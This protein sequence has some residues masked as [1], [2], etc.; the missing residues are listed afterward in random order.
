MGKRL[1]PRIIRKS[2]ELIWW[3]Q[4][5]NNSLYREPNEVGG[6]RWWSD[7]VGG[8]VVVWDTS[9]VD[10]QTLRDALEAEGVAQ[11]AAV[12]RGLRGE[13]NEMSSLQADVYGID[14]GGTEEELDDGDR[15]PRTYQGGLRTPKELDLEIENKELRHANRG[16][17]ERLLTGTI[18]PTLSESEVISRVNAEEMSVDMLRVALA[19]GR[20]QIEK[21]ENEVAALK[22]HNGNLKDDY[23]AMKARVRLD[24]DKDQKDYYDALKDAQEEGGIVAR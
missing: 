14:N 21:L 24:W 23:D 3:C 2:S 16:L 22:T 19:I 8:G 20:K 9:L 5:G 6:H 15:S 11:D 7:E 17:A 10:A 13:M 12:M 18:M 4:S 1:L